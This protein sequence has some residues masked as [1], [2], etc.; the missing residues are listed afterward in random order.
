MS[1]LSKL[2]ISGRL[3]F[4]LENKNRMSSKI[5][6]DTCC[7]SITDIKSHLVKT[8]VLKF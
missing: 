1:V 3:N 4:I 8:Q 6:P 5:Y 7:L 2:T